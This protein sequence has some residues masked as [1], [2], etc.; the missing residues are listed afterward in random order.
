MSGTGVIN[1]LIFV[2]LDAGQH[3]LFYHPFSLGLNFSQ[4]MRGIS[5]PV[6]SMELGMLI[7]RSAEDF[8]NRPL[9]V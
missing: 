9:N 2:E 7:P 1:D 8:V 6:N 4:V 3:S 5:W